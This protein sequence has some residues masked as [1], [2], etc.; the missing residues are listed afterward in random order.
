MAE[1]SISALKDFLEIVGIS[2]E[3]FGVYYTAQE[4]KDGFTPK[5]RSLPTLEEEKGD[6]INWGLVFEGFSC[7]MGCSGGHVKRVPA[8]ILAEKISVVLVE[9]FIWVF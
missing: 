9:P 5:S 6:K 7:V 8:L 2:E 3:P 4:P 1:N